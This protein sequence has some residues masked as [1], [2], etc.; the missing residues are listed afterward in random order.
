L[1]KI[2]VLLLFLDI[3]AIA[4]PRKAT[5]ILLVLVSLFGA[6]AALSSILACVPIQIFWKQGPG[7]GSGCIAGV[8]KWYADAVG[9]LV[10][11]IAIF[12][13]PL[14]VVWPMVLPWRQK[15]WLYIVF[16]L[17]LL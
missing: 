15:I 4:W 7:A 11:D 1:T 12:C 14:P 6:W 8:P 10:L 2:S 3:F 9:N 16:T 5:Y 17:G 13:L